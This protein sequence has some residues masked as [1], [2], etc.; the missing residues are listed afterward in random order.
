M[1]K[2]E[3]SMVLGTSGKKLTRGLGLFGALIPSLLALAPGASASPM[4]P[5]APT[6]SKAAP[7]ASL[8][9]D[10]GWAKSLGAGVVVVPPEHTAAGHGSPGAAIQGFVSALDGR[11]LN[12]WC[13]YYEPS[14]QAG[15]RA[16]AAKFVATSMPI[17]KNFALGYVAIDGNQ[18]LVGSTGTDCAANF[19]PRCS[20]NQ[21]PAAIFSTGRT[22]KVLWAQTVAAYSS[23][24][25]VY[26]LDLCIKISGRWYSYVP[27][28]T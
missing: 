26:S 13:S 27:P 21:S 8:N 22:F 15:C 20:S 23:T 24:A 4:S 5:I 3:P 10:P 1:T 11:Q 28:S 14:F 19:K 7:S 18:A 2:G 16:N 9:S 6:A 25:N 12:L 17:F